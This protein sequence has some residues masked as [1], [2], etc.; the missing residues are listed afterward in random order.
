MSKVKF[1]TLKSAVVKM[2]NSVDVARSYEIS[3]NVNVQSG[4]TVGT[5]DNGV[6]RELGV[7]EGN[8]ATFNAWSDTN[9]NYSF[10]KE[11]DKC[12]VIEAIDAFIADVKSE[13]ANGVDINV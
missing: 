9:A 1:E 8:I 4:N 3:A 7:D 2:N 6:I 13:V 5:I 11:C 12:D 10:N